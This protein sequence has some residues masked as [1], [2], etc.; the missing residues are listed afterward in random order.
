[1]GP[2]DLAHVLRHLT[3][4]THPALLVGL[5]TSDDAAVYQ[6]NADQAL[7]QTLDFFP[8]IV[9]DP[10]L[11][12][13][14]AAAN[15]LSD[16]YA[17]GGHPILAL[18]IAMWPEDLDRAL[19]A[20]VLQGGADKVAEA[21]AIV[22]GGHTVTDR[23]PKYGLSVTGIV[24]PA[25]LLT[26]GG[27]QPNDVLV[28]TKPIGTGV[29]TTAARAD[30]ARAA[31]LA[32]AVA[33]MTQLNRPASEALVACGVHAATDITGFG[34]L[35]HAYEMAEAGG[36]QLVIEADEVPL[37][38]GAWDYAEAGLTTG[39]G[40]R[41][42]AYLME[43]DPAAGLDRPRVR[44]RRP[45]PDPLQALLL[46]PQTSGGLLA[47]VPPLEYGELSA[48]LGDAGVLVYR[49]GEV[50]EGRGVTVT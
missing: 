37:L 24:H 2:G 35:G 34:L 9:D 10:Y 7:V 14:I 22:A 43:P 16:V 4:H 41:N 33:S 3:P 19:L 27:A 21:G 8:P 6:L 18:N 17:M 45:V 40:G 44:V 38:A 15:A 1:M 13:A 20:A 36:V 47:A 11:F 31:D 32:E 39:G 30:R 5:H 12:G 50:A 42:Y 28:L 49:I 48:R 25:H 29:I 23:E 26:K 46:D